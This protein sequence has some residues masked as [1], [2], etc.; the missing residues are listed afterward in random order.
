MLLD[1]TRISQQGSSFGMFVGQAVEAVA[2]EV[3]RYRP[4]CCSQTTTWLG[5][6]MPGAAVDYL[7]TNWRRSTSDLTDLHDW[8][9]SGQRRKEGQ[10][11]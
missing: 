2:D 8:S 1:S 7:P 4:G 6:P 10:D 9:L 11:P 5:P 3:P